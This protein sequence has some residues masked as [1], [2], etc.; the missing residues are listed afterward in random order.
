[1]RTLL[2]YLLRRRAQGGAGVVEFAI[3]APVLF[4]VMFT[5]IDFSL[6]L[7]GSTVGGNAAREGA[8]VGIIHYECADTSCS[9]DHNG[10]PV[11]NNGLIVTA[12]NR[13]LGSLVRGTP[14]TTVRCLDVD[15]LGAK[16]CQYGTIDLDRDLIEVKV[17]WQHIG[18]SPF[19]SN[20]SH[21]E[22]ARM[23]ISG[24][25]D[26]AATG[27]TTTSTTTST[28]TTTTAPGPTTTTTT[29]APSPTINTLELFD[30]DHD[31]KVD[32]VAA[33]FSAA[34]PGCTSGWSMAGA[35]SGGTLGAPSV[36]GNTVTLP[37]N[38]GAGAADTALGSL[39]VS[40]TPV[41]ACAATG[42]SDM[43][44]ADKANPVPLSVTFPSRGATPGLMEANDSIAVTFSE[45]MSGVPATPAAVTE[46]HAS[47][48]D[49]LIVAGLTPAGGFNTG[50][51]IVD[52]NKSAT[53]TGAGGNVA[54]TNLG[55]TITVTVSGACT[56][57]C[58]KLSTGGAA[59][60]TYAP[61]TSLRDLASNSAAGAFT[62][63]G[64]QIF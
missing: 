60:W 22:T 61:A 7:I 44:P 53:F 17:V 27:A 57:D 28:T 33:V 41:G 29:A 63:A 54:V 21:T 5:A 20:A 4:L 25:P 9:L 11:D 50:S 1:M 64:Q 58:N 62:S 30:D 23:V 19:V 52:N 31:G 46:T 55:K 12:V 42:F 45:A 6:I 36:A 39:Q 34:V 51:N 8:R 14:T 16:D 26:I 47:P 13:L 32:R 35:P 48:S 24:K 49:V 3:V 18:A 56:G 43:A 15:T 38:E 2:R 59:V 37:I 40:F 10:N